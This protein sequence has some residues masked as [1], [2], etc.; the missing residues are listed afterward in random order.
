VPGR[1]FSMPIMLHSRITQ[2]THWLWFV[3]SSI[4]IA[5]SS[6]LTAE[7][8]VIRSRDWMN[9]QFR[10]IAATIFVTQLSPRAYSLKYAFA[11]PVEPFRGIEPMAVHFFTFCLAGNLSSNFGFSGWALGWTDVEEKRQ[12]KNTTEMELHLAFVN[13]DEDPAVVA[14]VAGINWQEANFNANPTFR[15]NCSRT[16]R[17]EYMW[18]P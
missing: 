1:I 17:P 8:L 15:E 3:A 2:A 11:V 18:K 6:A 5:S 12:Y 9:P 4:C 7:S 13:D 10:D 16:L 14:G